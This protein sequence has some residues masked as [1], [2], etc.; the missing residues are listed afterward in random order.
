M[1][2]WW[3]RR[4][5][6]F[7][8][9]AWYACGGIVLLTAFCLVIYGFV[10]RRLA[11]PLDR[12]LKADLATVKARLKLGADGRLLWDGRGPAAG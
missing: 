5:L 7:R 10:E 9:A 6:R 11:Q 8:L 1:R 2:R 12:Q 4:S 3:R